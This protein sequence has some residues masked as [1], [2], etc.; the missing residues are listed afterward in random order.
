MFG[1]R[2]QLFGGR[3][4]NYRRRGRLKR[5][6]QV[7][8]DAGIS[9]HGG[10]VYAEEGCSVRIRNCTLTRNAARDATEWAQGGAIYGYSKNS[11]DVADSTLTLN[12]A[13]NGGQYSSGGVV[14]AEIDSS[15]NFERSMLERNFASGSMGLV[16]GGA[17]SL[18]SGSRGTVTNCGLLSNAVVGTDAA[19]SEGGAV[20]VEGASSDLNIQASTMK[21]N[22]ADSHR[23]ACG[24][25]IT[26]RRGASFSITDVNIS[27]ST[28]NGTADSLG[29]AVCVRSSTAFM[30]FAI[31]SENQGT[32]SAS[33]SRWRIILRG[34]F[35]F[36]PPSHHTGC[37]PRT[38]PA[39]SSRRCNVGRD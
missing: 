24:G 38:C 2:G 28:V 37:Q 4:R 25:A 14:F 21:R 26:A 16:F 39:Y 8:R 3:G 12:A 11:I 18:S 22:S 36:R 20:A 34:G 30:K 7:A 9:A 19:T 15:V 31:F 33:L 23:V 29:G 6:R 13:S 32:C 10:A 35:F 17:I 1:G 5:P 27:S